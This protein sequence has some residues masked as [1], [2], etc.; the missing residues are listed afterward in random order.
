MYADAWS[1][2]VLASISDSRYSPITMIAVPRIGN[3][4]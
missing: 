2:V 1:V 4:L 3:A